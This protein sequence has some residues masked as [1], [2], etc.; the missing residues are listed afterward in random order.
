MADGEVFDADA[1]GDLV[2]Q[3]AV[4][5]RRGDRQHDDLDRF[6]ARTPGK[7]RRSPP[8]PYYNAAYPDMLAVGI[9]QPR[10]QARG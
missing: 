1:G 10:T 9:Y 3:D 2:V 4:N 7:G 8:P 5:N 6:H